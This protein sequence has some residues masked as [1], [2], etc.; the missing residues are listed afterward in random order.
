MSPKARRWIRVLAGDRRRSQRYPIAADLE[1]RIVAANQ[2]IATGTGRCLNLSARGILFQCPAVL[3]VGTDV[4]IDVAW[5]ARLNHKLNLNL[6]LSGTVSRTDGA[7][8]AVFFL[9]Y[10]FR[11][12]GRYRASGPRFPTATVA[13][14]IAVPA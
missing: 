4:E 12:R 9:Q 7:L 8:H 13:S 14:P 3:P 2:V 1:Y 11:I 10:E 6:S 5:P